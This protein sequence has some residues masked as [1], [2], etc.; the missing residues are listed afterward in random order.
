MGP[1]ITSTGPAYGP[2]ITVPGD[3][4]LAGFAPVPVA[5]KVQSFPPAEGVENVALQVPPDAENPVTVDDPEHTPPQVA[6]RPEG[7]AIV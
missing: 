3:V 5:V 1:E 4:P 6:V 2:T 7:T